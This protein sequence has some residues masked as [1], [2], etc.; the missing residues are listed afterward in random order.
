MSKENSEWQRMEVLRL[1]NLESNRLTK[2]CIESALVLLMKEKNFNE[3]SITEIVKRAGVSRTAYY[4][5]YASKED[6]LHSM[7]QE[8]VNNTAKAMGLHDPD[9][10]LYEFW[11]T[12]F[13]SIKPFSETFQILLKANFG[14]TILYQINKK[15]QEKVTEGDVKGHYQQCFWSGAVYSILTE[16]VRTGMQ[17]TVEEMT[18]LC[19]TILAP[20]E[21]DKTI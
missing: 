5:N 21:P 18:R 19:C 14:E 15:L 6:V 16:W 9:K 4:R 8:V 12:M 3:I 13:D 1:S 17:Q 2:E 11:Y 10:N 7:V 20:P